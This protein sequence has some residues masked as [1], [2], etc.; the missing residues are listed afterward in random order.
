[1]A[2]LLLLA[3]AALAAAVVAAA[4]R[5]LGALQDSRAAAWSA[6]EAQLVKRHEHMIR[7][8][9]L[10]ARLMTG[11]RDTLERVTTSGS[12]VV[13]AVRRGNMPALAAAEK[14]HREA[15]A[16]LFRLAENYPQFVTSR[17]FSALRE[18]TATLHA[19]VDERRE[20]YNAAVSVL[21][22]RCGAFP[23]SL[24]A[25]TMGVRP[26]PFLS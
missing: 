24:V 23:Y 25:R 19:R 26:A 15:A 1:M 18:R 6:L 14:T 17:A 2:W 20:A 4:R 10:C 8:V 22:F 9:G 13:A 11:E 12:A 3:I 7:V 5:G 16:A 21:N